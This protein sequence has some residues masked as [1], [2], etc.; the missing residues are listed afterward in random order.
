MKK[1]Q[2][3]EAYWHGRRAQ[4]KW[5]KG[6]ARQGVERKHFSVRTPNLSVFGRLI[7]RAPRFLNVFN[8]EHCVE[9]LLFLDDLHKKCVEQKK[10]VLIDLQDTVSCKICAVLVLFA[11]IHSIQFE[12]GSPFVISITKSGLREIDIV[13]RE[14]GFFNLLR[15]NINYGPHQILTAV[16]GES[17]DDLDDSIRTCVK[18][19]SESITEAGLDDDIHDAMY[20]AVTESIINVGNHAYEEPDVA[21]QNF[22]DKVG[23]R[24]WFITRRIQDQLFV[25]IYDMGETIPRTIPRRPFYEEI[26]SMIAGLINGNRDSNLIKGSMEYGRSRFKQEKRGKGLSDIKAFVEANPDGQLMLYS[27]YGRYNYHT[28]ND[29]EELND[30]KRPLQGTLIQ[31]NIQLSNNGGS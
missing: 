30:S 16:S 10:R 26:T 13:F 8:E 28:K 22:V 29:V 9:F 21:L 31:W 14:T 25:A 24:W 20:A 11:H 1:I 7:I 12:T 6:L 18:Y 4:Q 23:K 5:V 3:D 15:G 19:V 27:R 17:L 2:T